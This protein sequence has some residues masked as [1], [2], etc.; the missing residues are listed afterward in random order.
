MLAPGG[1]VC[2]GHHCHAVACNSLQTTGSLS[3]LRCTRC[4]RAYHVDCMPLDAHV[5]S[6]AYFYCV[7][8]VTQGSGQPAALDAA[9]AV[10]TA[11]KRRDRSSAQWAA[12]SDRQGAANPTKR[13]RVQDVIAEQKRQAATA[14]AAAQKAVEAEA[15]AARAKAASSGG[16]GGAGFSLA[17]AVAQV[18]AAAAAAGPVAHAAA[19]PQPVLGR[20][21]G[22]L[23]AAQRVG[24]ASA[25][26]WQPPGGIAPPA[27]AAPASNAPP[28]P[29]HG[30]YAPSPAYG[31]QHQSPV[32]FAPSPWQGGEEQHWRGEVPHAP[33]AAEETVLCATDQAD[34]LGR[35]IF[36]DAAGA[37]V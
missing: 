12:E 19:A 25:M 11:G 2:Q 32:D 14:A 5:L 1:V 31:Y 21:R 26:A 8:H 30:A 15:E 35:Q 37:N 20:G 33:F 36:I 6:D 34:E 9:A 16:G 10:R 17:A 18:R 13:V 28:F 23:L 24:P 3:L 22:A 7:Q 4:P 29:H 27:H